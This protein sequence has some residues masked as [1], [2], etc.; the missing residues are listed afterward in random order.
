MGKTFC[1]V[2]KKWCKLLKRGV[3]TFHNDKIENVN[4]CPRLAES[5]TVRLI[6]LLKRVNFDDTFKALCTWHSDQEKSKNGYQNVFNTLLQ[7]KPKK[8]NLSDL[9]IVVEKTKDD[10]CNIAYL[11][12]Y[13]IS[14]IT[15]KRYGIEFVDWND[16]ISMFIYEQT[17][18]SLTPEEIVGACLYEMTF[19][20]F[21][22]EKIK[23]QLQNMVD[24]IEEMKNK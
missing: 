6:E 22:E 18:N 16:W 19:Y 9:L 3:C 1:K 5:E 20:G 8:H 2:E 23:Q 17:F 4:R 14:P 13:G 7:M 12:T 10:I 15:K 21:E 11:D 24:D